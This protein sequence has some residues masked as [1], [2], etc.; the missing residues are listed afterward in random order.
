MLD[1]GLTGLP[2]MLAL[3]SGSG[4]GAMM[5]EY[6]AHAA[7][8]E[9]RVLA[10]PVTAQTTAVGGSVE[11]HASFALLSARM[12]EQA[13]NAALVA[14]ATELVVAVRALR[15][16]GVVPSGIPA[17]DFYQRAAAALDPNLEDRPL[18][19]DVEAAGRLLVEVA[20]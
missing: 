17:A 6:T 10:A 4:S 11:S 14:T 1:P 2:R 5:L 8:A 16:R 18:T 13:V 20:G 9:V 19:D 12:A 7:A 3:E 15:M